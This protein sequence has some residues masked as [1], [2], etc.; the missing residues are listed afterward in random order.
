[1]YECGIC[2]K[3]YKTEKRMFSH[4]SKRHRSRNYISR[5]R[6][7]ISRT[8]Y[9]SQSRQDS[10]FEKQ[11]MKYYTQIR[12]LENENSQLKSYY[13]RNSEYDHER[14]DAEYDHE[15]RDSEMRNQLY[16]QQKRF[17]NEKSLIE[18]RLKDSSNN[19]LTTL[20]NTVTDL[21][22]RLK[23]QDESEKELIRK[24]EQKENE[25][26][27]LRTIATEKHHKSYGLETEKGRLEKQISEYD[28]IIEKKQKELDKLTNDYELS[29]QSI[30]RNFQDRLDETKKLN[31]EKIK[32]LEEE[33][34]NQIDSEKNTLAKSLQSMQMAAERTIT[35][36]DKKYSTE[37]N[38]K[39]QQIKAF[40][41]EKDKEINLLRRQIRK[42]QSEA[43]N[44]QASYSKL[45]EDANK[46]KKEFLGKL[47]QQKS[48]NDLKLKQSKA[49]MY[50]L[51]KQL[52][53]I[54]I[55]S[56]SIIL[57]RDRTIGS[58]KAKQIPFDENKRIVAEL[59]A[60]IMAMTA[61]FNKKYKTLL[62]KNHTLKNSDKNSD[63]NKEKFQ[64]EIKLMTEDFNKKYRALLEE[65][66][67][68]KNS[69][70]DREE[71]QTKIKI[72][73]E[74][75]NKKKRT[76]LEENL[77]IKNELEHLNNILKSSTTESLSKLNKV[78]EE[79]KKLKT[80]IERLNNI[81]KKAT[82]ESVSKLNRLTKQTKTL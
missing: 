33:Y 73:T 51:E 49:M 62:E 61:D 56:Q 43:V 44:I 65:N 55:D 39:D 64:A 31:I 71:L 59:Q 47:N 50:T 60:K 18:Q 82:V 1:M 78:S 27:Q 42:S 34:K 10:R 48:D 11:A 24:Y 17:E 72:I 16:L 36:K 70:Q 69:N 13:S 25:L 14:R 41:T 38:Q 75:F 7:D 67:K 57:K 58:L 77:E 4:I 35:R 54:K 81:I 8:S 6:G 52:S 63:K 30:K 22:N 21:A 15:R 2:L 12:L 9:I 76:I 3:T 46:L 37:I 29:F 68:L 28:N 32:E 23:S 80:E 19:Q 5:T 26:E 79:N 45:Q 40:L 74:D 53:N 66:L 20:Q